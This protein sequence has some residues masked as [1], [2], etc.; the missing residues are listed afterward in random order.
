MGWVLLFVVVFASLVILTAVL[1]ARQRRPRDHTTTV[2]EN[3]DRWLQ[4][5]TAV[6]SQ[7]RNHTVTSP[8]PGTAVVA[9]SYRPVWTIVVAI[10]FFPIGLLA[11][12]V[13]GEDKGTAVVS[14]K[15]EAQAEVHLQGVFRP[16]TV[17]AIN[18]TIS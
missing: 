15:G 16:E 17:E 3:A 6:V 13:K 8:V 12:L 10:L 1:E 14:P 9:H 2:G 18:A 11:L 4:S 5:M 7:K